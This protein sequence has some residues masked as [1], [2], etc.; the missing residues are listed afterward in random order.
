MQAQMEEL[1]KSAMPPGPPP[2]GSGGEP[3]LVSALWLAGYAVAFG[4]LALRAYQREERQKF[5]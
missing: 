4:A 2:V 1:Y 5:S 3:P